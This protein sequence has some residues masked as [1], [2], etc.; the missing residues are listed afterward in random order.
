MWSMQFPLCLEMGQAMGDGGGCNEKK[1]R[2]EKKEK[3][4]LEVG[5]SFGQIPC[6]PGVG[7]DGGRWT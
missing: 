5:C 2:R 3:V 1:E 4:M 7:V 6:L